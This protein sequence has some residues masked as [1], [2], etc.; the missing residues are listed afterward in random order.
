MIIDHFP[1][2]EDVLVGGAESKLDEGESEK[3]TG[4]DLYEPEGEPDTHERETE[5]SIDERMGQTTDSGIQT[6]E[7]EKSEPELEEG[8][9]EDMSVWHGSLKESGGLGH[10]RE[11]VDYEKADGNE[12]DETNDNK[13]EDNYAEKDLTEG[14]ESEDFRGRIETTDENEDENYDERDEMEGENEDGSVNSIGRQKSK[15]IS[16]SWPCLAFNS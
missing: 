3:E 9:D 1:E 15:F 10:E 14:T 7:S 13:R 6:T 2:A 8:T 11:N 12:I 4:T 5:S 16:V